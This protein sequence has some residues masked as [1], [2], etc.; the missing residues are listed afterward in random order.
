MLSKSINRTSF[1]NCTVLLVVG[2]A[3]F[4]VIGCGGESVPAG[5]ERVSASG[6]SLLTEI[7][8]LPAVSPLF[9]KG[10]GTLATARS[11]TVN[12]KGKMARVPS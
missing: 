4:S 8:F 1:L 7:R 11:K 2:A 3:F 12:M 5:R 10:L 6:M 9:M